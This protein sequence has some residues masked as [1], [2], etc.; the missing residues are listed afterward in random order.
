MLAVQECYISVCKEKDVLE[1]REH[2]RAEEEDARIK[3]SEV[4]MEPSCWWSIAAPEI[5]GSTGIKDRWRCTT[6]HLYPVYTLLSV[7]G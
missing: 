3:E 4:R 1:Q 5:R 7:Q 6:A 2:G